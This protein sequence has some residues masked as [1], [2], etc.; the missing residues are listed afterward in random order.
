MAI[1]LSKVLS[2]KKNRE[3][4]DYF[5]VKGSTISEIMKKVQPQLKREKDYRNQVDRIEKLIIEK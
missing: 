5:G 1:Y 4:G 2:G 3:V